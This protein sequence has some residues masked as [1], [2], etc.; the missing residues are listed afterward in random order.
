M[1]EARA[2][3]KSSAVRPMANQSAFPKGERIMA[4]WMIHLRIADALLDQIPELDRTAFVIGN[5]APDSG[6]PNSD[7]SSFAPPKTVTHYHTGNSKSKASKADID[8]FRADYFTKQHIRSYSRK[9]YS[10]FLGYYI[11]LLTD[12]RWA[13]KIVQP[14]KEQY[15]E[16]CA[17][18]KRA[19]I[20]RM[21]E[22]WYDLDFRYLLEHPDFRAFRIYEQAVGFRNE[23][24]KEFS[25]DAFDNRREYICS[26]Y[27]SDEHG[28]LYREYP[29]L[30]PE[31][32]E[33][34]V[35]ETTAFISGRISM[36]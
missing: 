15:P 5:I 26:F 32:A 21:K 17:A 11:H 12:I 22:D 13:E 29:Y 4:S 19:F 20:D 6:V 23:F 34:F 35:Q 9:A 30:N 2:D 10:F 31:Q 25:G 1:K 3:S 36:E 16:E 7:W 24:M 14:A 33:Q 27:R 28:P 8:A 18:N